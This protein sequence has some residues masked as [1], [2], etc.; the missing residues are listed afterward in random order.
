ML[1]LT[2]TVSEFYY[3]ARREC[4]SNCGRCMVHHKMQQRNRIANFEPVSALVSS[5]VYPFKIQIIFYY[6]MKY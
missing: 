4:T 5:K 6:V 3:F 1:A 2:F